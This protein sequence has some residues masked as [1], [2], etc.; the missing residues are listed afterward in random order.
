MLAWLVITTAVRHNHVDI[1][2]ALSTTLTDP[3]LSTGMLTAGGE[4]PFSRVMVEMDRLSIHLGVIVA[5]FTHLQV[6]A[7]GRKRRT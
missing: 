6:S 2:R 3:V 4:G 1:A 5:S 7:P